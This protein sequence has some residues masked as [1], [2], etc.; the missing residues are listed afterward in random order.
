[1]PD[2]DGDISQ[3]LKELQQSY[4]S[5]LPQ[6][7]ST[8]GD[9][10]NTV[11]Q[12]PKDADSL[13]ALYRLMHRLNGSGMT[14]GFPMVSEI[15]GTLER[16]LQDLVN[17]DMPAT[18]DQ[19]KHI[20][21]VLRTLMTRIT[22]LEYEP[23]PQDR[24]ESI[25]V[26]PPSKPVDDTMSIVL[27]TV[28][29]DIEQDMAHQLEYFGYTVRL[30]P[31]L[32][33]LEPM[34]K[35]TP[36]TAL[37]LDIDT[38]DGISAGFETVTAMQNTRKIPLPIIFISAQDVLTTRLQAVRA[39]GSA[40]FTKPVDVSGLIDTLD[41]V[42]A[43]HPPE[44]YR[45]LIIED[46]PD[47]AMYYS[48]TLEQAGMFTWVQTDPLLVMQP[49]EEFRPDLVL[50]DLYMPQCDGLELA[51]VIRQQPAYVS[52]PLV[53]LSTETNLAHHLTALRLGGDDFLTKPISA[54]H[55]IASLTAR[56]LR[57]RTLRSFMVRDSLTG[58]LNHTTTVEHLGREVARAERQQVP[59]SFA[60]I[61]IDHFKSVNDTYGHPI[62]D[63]VLKSLARLL[64]QRLR[65]TDIIGR[66]GG[67]EFALV[68]TGTEGPQAVMVINE[69][70]ESF[71]Q[72]RQQSDDAE[73]H[74]TL[75][76]G[77][78]SIA[79]YDDTAKLSDAADKAL[80]IAKQ[81]GRNR[82][83]LADDKVVA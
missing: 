9:L 51:A 40:Y 12:N 65:Q 44:P 56:V 4:L 78:A 59:L 25:T 43:R 33:D 50:T 6:D 10:W 61:D 26:P 58:L 68:L 17:Q 15:A 11:Q 71:R 39:G 75:S 47:L 14:F 80:Y 7:M 38:A 62:G 49:L 52:I 28:D 81:S 82:I 69:I 48:N 64:Q 24:I 57:A 73:F 74:V 29:A 79:A 67:E 41:H 55:L 70:R 30:I 66:Y 36:P 35:E 45:I 63:R 34:L 5:H 20:G 22:E 53:F 27:V 1:M 23:P 76:G 77:V 42:T 21:M 19:L 8:A 18:S 54:N 60:M 83:V 31:K 13:Q 16:A 37:I 2:P 32:A 72:I 3:K 46:D